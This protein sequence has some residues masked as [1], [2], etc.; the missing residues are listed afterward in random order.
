MEALSDVLRMEVAQ[1]GIDVVVIQPGGIATESVD[2]AADNL[3]KTSGSG[4]DTKL[5]RADVGH[6]A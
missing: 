4:A 5:A 1:F 2:I 3:D 6:A